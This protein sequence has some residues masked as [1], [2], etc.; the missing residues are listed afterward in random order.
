MPTRPLEHECPVS[1]TLTGE[2]ALKEARSRGRLAALHVSP[3]HWLHAPALQ[4]PQDIS[5]SDYFSSKSRPIR[6]HQGASLVFRMPVTTFSSSHRSCLLTPLLSYTWGP[7][8][9][10]QSLSP[11]GEGAPPARKRGRMLVTSGIWVMAYQEQR[12]RVC[13]LLRV[14]PGKRVQEEIV[15]I[16]SMKT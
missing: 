8:S 5:E 4:L 15:R 10:A 1:G 2:E 14:G 12:P 13:D 3:R 9:Q 16:Y 6:Q 7:G 11:Q